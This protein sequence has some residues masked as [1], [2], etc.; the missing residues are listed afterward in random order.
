M[1]QRIGLPI[2][3]A[4]DSLPNCT[5]CSTFALALAASAERQFSRDVAFAVWLPLVLAA[6]AARSCDAP[7]AALGTC[8]DRRTH[9]L[10]LSSFP[11]GAHASVQVSALKNTS[12][13]R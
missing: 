7:R 1:S 4:L 10:A 12:K 8:E 9:G 2:R 5:V 3:I 11:C 6:F 13:R